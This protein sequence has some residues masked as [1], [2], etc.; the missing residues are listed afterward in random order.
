VPG[1]W[2]RQGE[3]FRLYTA[4]TKKYSGNSLG[5]MAAKILTESLRGQFTIHESKTNEDEIRTV[6]TIRLLEMKT[7]D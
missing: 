1:Q 4:D 3:R 5:L 2:I 7:D 6:F